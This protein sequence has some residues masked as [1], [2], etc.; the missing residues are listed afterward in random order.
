MVLT[1]R[2]AL[3]LAA[4][5][6]L[7]ATA[8]CASLSSLGSDE[9]K[10]EYTLDVDRIDASPVEHALYDPGDD[11]LFGEPARTAL[12]AI[13]PEGRHTT[14]GYEPLPEGAYVRRGETYYQTESVVTGRERM[15]RRLVR[16]ESVPD[17]DV[18][19]D[20]LHVDD[21]D[22]PS[23]RAVKILHSNAVSG[24][25]SGATDLLRGDAYV[26]RRPAELESRLATGDL[27]GRIVSMTEDGGWAYRVQVTRERI[28]ET[29]HTALAVEVADGRS[30]F[31]EVVFG[32]RIDA[33]L[34]PSALTDGE[35]AVLEQAVSR[36][37]YVETAPRS[38]DFDGVLNALGLA[39]VDTA[40]TGQLLWYDGELYRYGL[41]VNDSP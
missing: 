5:T 7:A 4:A 36:G 28:Q 27:D 37:R 1:R 33:E 17:A 40:E 16:V 11:G 2:S 9:P 39:S 20:P 12:D 21:L 35:R 22:R 6:S 10:P 23:A 30:A 32:S 15:E 25:A 38:S 14:Y 8:G 19:D 34:A 31:R 26:L 41:Y 24:G 3:H 13:L 29:A 18:P